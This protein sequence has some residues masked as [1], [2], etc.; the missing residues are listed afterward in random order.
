VKFKKK[1][2]FSSSDRNAKL[3]KK[4]MDWMGDRQTERQTNKERRKHKYRGRRMGRAQRRRT[5]TSTLSKKEDSRSFEG[6][7][8]ALTLVESMRLY[9]AERKKRNG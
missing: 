5:L 1:V 4:E 2:F 3:S 8:R 9:S 6:F 7:N